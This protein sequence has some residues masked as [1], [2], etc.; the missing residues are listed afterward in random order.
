MALGT[1]YRQ[2]LRIAACFVVLSLTAGPRIPVPRGVCD[3][4]RPP[5]VQKPD[6]VYPVTL[7]SENRSGANGFDKA[8]PIESTFPSPEVLKVRSRAW[9][10][11]TPV[12]TSPLAVQ[13]DR[14]RSPPRFA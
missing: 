5:V 8:S 9:P 12:P 6:L 2:I 1:L 14:L 7:R 4:L 11:R 3:P 10:D 13:Q